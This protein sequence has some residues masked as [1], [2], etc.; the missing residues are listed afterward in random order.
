MPGRKLDGGRERWT[1]LPRFFYCTRV[2]RLVALKR[3]VASSPAIDN[4]E[5][6]EERKDFH[7]V[8]V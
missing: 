1:S 4:G 5:R 6:L 2:D 8:A 7:D 3:E